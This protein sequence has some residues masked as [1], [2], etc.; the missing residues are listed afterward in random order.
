MSPFYAEVFEKFS[1]LRNE[2]Q[3]L[4]ADIL[5]VIEGYFLK[6]INKIHSLPESRWII[7]ADGKW[8]PHESPPE[9]PLTFSGLCGNLGAKLIE[10]VLWEK[11]CNGYDFNDLERIN[12]GPS[13][14][15]NALDNLNLLKL[16]C[17]SGTIS[18]EER[19]HIAGLS[20]WVANSFWEYIFR[21]DEDFRKEIAKGRG[22]FS[23]QKA[24]GEKKSGEKAKKWLVIGKEIYDSHPEPKPTKYKLA[25][26]IS[27]RHEG[28]DATIRRAL[29]PL[30]PKKF[31]G[32]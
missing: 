16:Y 32:A 20:L 23:A 7:E 5:D 10:R 11:E 28:D 21:Y 29:K 27:E 19:N 14:I 18:Y 31:V 12:D 9:H 3:P 6:R 30:Y 2:S 25:K 4:Y 8:I 1:I 15:C 26:L 13:H 22:F 24:G 17:L